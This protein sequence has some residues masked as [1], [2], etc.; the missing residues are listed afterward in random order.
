MRKL[1]FLFIPILSFAQIQFDQYFITKSLRI[2]FELL[3]NAQ[4]EFVVLSEI[5]QEPYWGGNPQKTVPNYQFGDYGISVRDLKGKLLFYKGFN[6]LFR[7]WQTTSEAKKINRSFHHAMQVPYPKEKVKINISSRQKNGKFKTLLEWEVNPNDYLIS[8]EKTT[9]YPIDTVSYAGKSSDFLDIV[10]I[11]EGYTK[12][13]IPK[14]KKDVRRFRDWIFKVV[15]FSEYKDKVNIYALLTPSKD[16]GPDIP[17]KHVYN[18]TL[19]N[20]SFYTF[21]SPRYLTVR[22]TKKMCDIASLVPYDHVYVLVNTDTYGGAGF[23][24][25]Y[26]SCA[27]DCDYAEQIASHELGHGLIGLADEYYDNKNDDISYYYDLNN[28]PWEPNLTTLVDFSKKWKHLVNKETPI[29][30]PRTRKYIQ[31]IGAFEGG[32]YQSKGIYSPMQDC[33]MKSNNTDELCPVCKEAI[34]KIMDFYSSK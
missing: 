27:S 26:T 31:K 1:L 12:S 6:S 11:A 16:S 2:D 4:Q 24:N 17:G 25:T 7:E 21:N 14:F 32:A 10:F 28:E 9:M 30:T 23:Y 15:P 29:P 34:R 5:K 19:L 13:E 3:G 20:S 22:D 18:E 8:R 33:K